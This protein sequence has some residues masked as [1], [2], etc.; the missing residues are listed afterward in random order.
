M[1]VAGRKTAFYT[2]DLLIRIDPT[3]RSQLVA[4][5]E[6][7]RTSMSELIRRSV[8]AALAG[9]DHASMPVRGSQ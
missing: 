5:A 9:Q 6:R 7:E 2:N 8:R 4:A 1:M 3:L